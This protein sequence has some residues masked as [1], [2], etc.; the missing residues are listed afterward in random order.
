MWVCRLTETAYIVEDIML[1]EDSVQVISCCPPVLYG[2]YKRKGDQCYGARFSVRLCIR[3]L[4]VPLTYLFRP[5]TREEK[6]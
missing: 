4:L 1:Q 6:V 5:K 2:A 3:M